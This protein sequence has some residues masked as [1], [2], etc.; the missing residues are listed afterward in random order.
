MRFGINT[1][2]WTKAFAKADLGLIE[3]V[4]Q[5]GADGIEFAR[6]GFDGFPVEAIRAELDRTGMACTLCTAPPAPELSVIHP[7]PQARARSVAYL[8][9]AIEVAAGLGSRLVVGP[10]YAHVGWFTGQRR[11][12]LQWAWAIEAFQALIPDLERHDVS[13]ALEP[14][15]RFEG[16]FLAT[17]AEGRA[18]CEAIG[19][20][21]VGLLLDTVHMTIEDKSLADAVRR[22][23]PWLRHMHTP[24]NDRGTPG[25]G[26]VDWP[27]LFGAL[28]EVG[29]DGW[30]TIESF[31]WDRPDVAAAT[32]CWR[33]LAVSP[34][35]LGLEGVAFLRGAAKAAMAATAVEA[36]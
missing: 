27:A 24:E 5:L 34:D 1:F 17:S 14:L 3:H 6:F 11:T 28:R 20:P 23:G 25:T 36:G 10:L 12:P 15:N 26:L 9:E 4:Q 32:F 2:L 19:H 7:D 18:L 16:F 31:A 33:D 21:R 8:R 35:A 29:Y 30:C 22:A 13:F